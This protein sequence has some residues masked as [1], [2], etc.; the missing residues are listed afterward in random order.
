MRCEESKIYSSQ[1][2]RYS[3]LFYIMTCLLLIVGGVMI[4]STIFYNSCISHM[5]V[6][7][8]IVLGYRFGC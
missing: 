1:E 4:L 6:C 7:E 2:R 3:E 5:G 8:C